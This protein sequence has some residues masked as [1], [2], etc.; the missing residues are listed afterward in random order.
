MWLAADKAIRLV[1]GLVVGLVVARHL[2]PESFGRLQYAIT[3]L[4]VLGPLAELG[5]EPLVRRRL[6]D[7][8][9]EAGKVLAAVFRLRL[10][11]GLISA[12]GLAAYAAL[13]GETDEARGLLWILCLGL[14]QA[15]GMTP[16]I[17][18]HATL[19]ARVEVVASWVALA[20]G[21]AAKLACV[22]SGAGLAAFA[23]VW[24]GEAWLTCGLVWALARRAGLPRLQGEE[25][26]RTGRELLANSWPVLASGLF[27]LI[28]MRVDVVLL[29]NLAGEAETGVYVAAVKFSELGYFVPV[30]LASSLLPWL[31]KARAEGEAAYGR[32]VQ[33]YYDLNLALAHVIV[34]PILWLAEP[35]IAL[36]YGPDFAGAAEVLRWHAPAAFFV[37]A[38]V[39]RWQVLFNEGRQRFGLFCTVAGTALNIGLNA[40]LIPRYGAQG[41]AMGTVAAQAATVL[42]MQWLHPALRADT[43]RLALAFLVP[44]RGW[45]HLRRP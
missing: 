22:W 20:A 26:A 18:L 37:F 40:W 9:E 16:A 27:V 2:G 6:I 24:V 45:R 15:A 7:R 12:A 43:V 10:A 41:A 8:P 35:V 44:L 39:A 29:R 34:W 14:S 17:W 25:L 30:A 4:V 1:A 21:S 33:K 38:G 11:A 31:L 32:A 28:N 3:L 5:L 13:G 42:G 19:R 23:W 36:A